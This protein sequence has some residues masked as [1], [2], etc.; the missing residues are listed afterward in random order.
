MNMAAVITHATCYL[1][2]A[3][4]SRGTMKTKRKRFMGDTCT[5]SRVIL[6]DFSLRNFGKKVSHFS[7]QAEYLCYKCH[8]TLLSFPEMEKK[9][10]EIEATLKCSVKSLLERKDSLKKRDMTATDENSSC[11][12]RMRLET[13]AADAS[14]SSTDTPTTS[15]GSPIQS[16]SKSVSVSELYCPMHALYILYD[17]SGFRTHLETRITKLELHGDRMPSKEL[18][19]GVLIKHQYL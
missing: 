8:N 4:V 7:Y 5:E 3:D 12:K 14:T 15:Y 2:T 1:C 16:D 9:L 17:R 13:E 18:R 6:D 19:D 10:K 11:T